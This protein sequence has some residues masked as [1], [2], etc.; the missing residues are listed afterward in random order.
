M[1]HQDCHNK[2]QKTVE[3]RHSVLERG[4]ISN[5][6]QQQH[7]Q[8]H[9]NRLLWS[10]ETHQVVSW[11]AKKLSVTLKNRI[12][13]SR[14]T[15]VGTTHS[16]CISICNQIISRKMGVKNAHLNG[17]TN[18]AKNSLGSLEMLKWHTMQ[19]LTQLIDHK[20]GVWLNNSQTLQC[21]NDFTKNSG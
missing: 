7:K 14:P 9:N 16:I 21:T 2:Q 3:V 8:Q 18:I 15:I 4:D 11:S 10:S 19:I 12:A 6:I 17:T 5:K 1:Q 13:N 20:C